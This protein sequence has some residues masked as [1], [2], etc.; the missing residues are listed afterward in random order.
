MITHLLETAELLYSNKKYTDAIY[1]YNILLKDFPYVSQ[2][3]Y[4]AARIYMELGKFS[5]AENL[6]LNGMQKNPNDI[7][8]YI[9]FAKISMWKSNFN[10][11]VQRYLTIC[12]KFPEYAVGYIQ[13]S[14]A[15]ENL[16]NIKTSV[17]IMEQA[18]NLFKNN[19]NILIVYINILL[20]Q[21]KYQKACIYSLLML[22]KNPS[23]LSYT[24]CV[25]I[26]KYTN[27][28]LLSN[29]LY[30]KLLKM[31]LPYKYEYKTGKI[32][33]C[34]GFVSEINFYKPVLNFFHKNEIDVIMLR[35]P[36]FDDYKCN[37]FNIVPLKKVNI[38]SYITV[39]CDINSLHYLPNN[40]T[41]IIGVSHDASTSCPEQYLKKLSCFIC[42]NK[43]TNLYSNIMILNEFFKKYLKLI[44][45]NYKC[46]VAYTGPYHIR[47][48]HMYKNLTKHDKYNNLCE[49][50]GKELPRDKPIIAF[51]EDQLSN[52]NQIAFTI[53]KLQQFCTVIYKPIFSADNIK[54][55]ISNDT[56]LCE[57]WGF[58]PN[59]LR[60]SVDFVLAGYQSGTFLSSN[61]LGVPVIGFYSRLITKKAQLIQRPCFWTAKIPKYIDILNCNAQNILLYKYY[62]ANY[63]FDLL[64]IERIKNAILGTEYLDWYH[65]NLLSLQKEAF[66][67]YMLEGAAE[68]TAE[69]IMRFAREGTLGKDCS[70]VYLKEQYF[71]QS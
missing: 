25:N 36:E 44:N 56:I 22:T 5:K 65:K 47:N 19:I 57:R 42:T 10:E 34:V 58:S 59:V 53:N 12:K 45:C 41:N 46:E 3:Y 27:N 61:M 20:K 50:A 66:G 33:F 16:E 40:L 17:I 68:K 63:L 29:I 11:A 43:K 24:Y 30:E 69:Y 18:I 2:S 4:K 6:C 1:I 62:K 37:D 35:D 55:K 54:D 26:S 51:F 14:I 21:Q 70:A 38:S 23:F 39:V 8:N 9:N 7:S 49:I 28:E 67:D 13:L 64:D 15:Y 32:A 71:K 52:E 48:L 60:F 31:N